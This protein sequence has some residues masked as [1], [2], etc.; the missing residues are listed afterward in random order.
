MIKHITGT[1]EEWSWRNRKT[2]LS[3]T[4]SDEKH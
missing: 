1:L 2:Q 3:R 4:V